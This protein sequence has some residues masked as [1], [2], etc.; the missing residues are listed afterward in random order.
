MSYV[1]LTTI[2]YF[3]GEIQVSS[4]VTTSMAHCQEIAEATTY[5]RGDGIESESWCSTLTIV[6]PSK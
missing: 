5:D 6:E 4:V 1:I 3:H 2:F